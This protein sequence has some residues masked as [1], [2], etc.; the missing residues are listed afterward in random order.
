MLYKRKATKNAHTGHVIW[1]SIDSAIWKEVRGGLIAPVTELVDAHSS[2]GKVRLQRCSA[3]RRRA[4]LR[5]TSRIA[6]HSSWLP[7]AHARGWQEKSHGAG[8]HRL[9]S[10][11]GYFLLLRRF[12]TCAVLCLCIH[13]MCVSKLLHVATWARGLCARGVTRFLQQCRFDTS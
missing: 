1:H 11:S 4:P 9:G 13:G 5:R 10:V 2:C 6:G 8:A 3:S 12:G 7:N